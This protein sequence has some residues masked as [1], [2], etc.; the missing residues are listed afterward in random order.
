MVC[1][2]NSCYYFPR[3]NFLQEIE[4]IRATSQSRE[5]ELYKTRNLD[6]K[7]LNRSQI[8]LLKSLSTIRPTDWTCFLIDKMITLQIKLILGHYAEKG[9][10]IGEGLCF[11]LSKVIIQMFSAVLLI[12]SLYGHWG[13]FAFTV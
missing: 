6:S 8:I 9:E 11:F 4:S 5:D 13:P 12:F 3:S 7:P 1:N 2:K 10:H